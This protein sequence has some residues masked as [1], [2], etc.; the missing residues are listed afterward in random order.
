VTNELL[1]TPWCARLRDGLGAINSYTRK[2]RCDKPWKWY[3]FPLL[4]AATKQLY[5]AVDESIHKLEAVK[6]GMICDPH[7]VVRAIRKTDDA[8]AWYARRLNGLL[9]GY[10]RE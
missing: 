3:H 9:A 4:P 8:V 1:V 2:L 6:H 5:S 7:A 10:E